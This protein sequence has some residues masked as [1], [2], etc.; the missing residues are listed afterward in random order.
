MLSLDPKW[1]VCLTTLALL[2][3]G[4]VAAQ[5]PN[6]P[7]K[8]VRIIVG[9]APGGGTDIIARLLAQ[10]LTEATGQSFLVENRPGAA[11]N[12]ATEYI[13][14]APPDG[15][16]LLMTTCVHAINASL[17]ARLPFDPV[18]DFTAVGVVGGTSN[19]LATHP[20]MPVKSLRELIALAKA[21][22]GEISYAHAGNGTPQHLAMELFRSMA[23]IKLLAVPYNGAGPSTAAVLGGQLP[24]LTSSLVVVLPHARAGKLRALGVTSAER[25]PLAPDVPTVAEAAG[26]P[27]YEAM[28]WFGL[29]APAGT[30]AAVVN[31]ISAE[32]ERQY[33]Q[34]EFRERLAALG[35]EPSRSSPD[36]L[37]QL[38]KSDIVK[39]GKAVRE[40]GAKAD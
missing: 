23:G 33:Q 2:G 15:Y 32:V 30:P 4:T 31:R 3:A 19:V 34:R 36:E 22:P 38:I 9:F 14:K 18:K 35:F 21:R 16:A 28:V 7:A 6:Y 1:C 13:A 12:I 17:Y 20:S 39:W 5:T 27:G 10:R 25:S 40:S 26:L 8:P 24:L 29:L 11:G 37:A